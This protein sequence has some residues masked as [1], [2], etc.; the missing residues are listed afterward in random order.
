LAITGKGV[1]YF[2]TQTRRLEEKHS[3][4][5]ELSLDIAGMAGFEGYSKRVNPTFEATLGYT[6]DELLKQPFLDFVH[7]DDVESPL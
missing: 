4:W 5:F 1:G 6:E 7:P 3:R 2:R